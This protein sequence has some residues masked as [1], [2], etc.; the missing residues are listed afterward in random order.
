MTLGFDVHLEKD[1]HTYWV[2]PGDSGSAVKL[3]LKGEVNRRVLD[4]L[5]GPIQFPIPERFETGPIT[6]FV[7]D[8]EVMFLADVVVPES[9]KPGDKRDLLL[10]AEWLVCQDVCIPGVRHVSIGSCR[11]ARPMTSARAARPRYSR[12][13]ADDC[14]AC[15]TDRCDV[16]PKR[17]QVRP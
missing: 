17:I 8:N 13:G 10:D 9:V 14:R 2:N 16:T 3:S 5:T 15:R 1:W 7:Y 6:S 4:L 12:I 11:S